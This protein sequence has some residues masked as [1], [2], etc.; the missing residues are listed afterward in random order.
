MSANQGNINC[1]CLAESPQM[2]SSLSCF[3]CLW[4]NHSSME[5]VFFQNWSMVLNKW[6]KDHR[7]AGPYILSRPT[8]H[9]FH[10]ETEDQQSQV[11][12][13]Q[14]RGDSRLAP[15]P[16][17]LQHTFLLQVAASFSSPALPRPSSS[18]FL[19]NSTISPKLAQFHAVSISVTCITMPQ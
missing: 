4:R 11:C 5:M 16:V 1:N 17:D 3:L 6:G 14:S 13:G 7:A 19:S 15:W 18:C 8:S 9:F 2:C 10:Q 12:L